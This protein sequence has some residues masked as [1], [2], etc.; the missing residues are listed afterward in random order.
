MHC[1]RQLDMPDLRQE[2]HDR[3][4]LCCSY[5]KDVKWERPQIVSF[6]IVLDNAQLG[7][8]ERH[9]E[10]VTDWPRQCHLFQPHDCTIEGERGHALQPHFWRSHRLAK[11]VVR[12]W[13]RISLIRNKAEHL[14]DVGPRDD[15]V[16]LA[17]PEEVCIEGVLN[18]RG[19]VRGSHHGKHFQ[20]LSYEQF[21]KFESVFYNLLNNFS[22]FHFTSW[23]FLKSGK[24]MNKTFTTS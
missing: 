21:F 4:A 11:I 23:R 24:T 6:R 14:Q 15:Q 5:L 9:D 12:Q 3:Q 7:L 20:V 8:G 22:E 1:G 13:C 2:G 17:I 18:P 10:R 19:R 16:F